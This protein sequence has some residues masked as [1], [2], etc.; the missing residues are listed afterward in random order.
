MSR[1]LIFAGAYGLAL[2]L[3]LLWQGLGEKDADPS[4]PELEEGKRTV[5]IFPGARQASPLLESLR[6]TFADS[7][8]VQILVREGFADSEAALAWD[9][10]VFENLDTGLRID[11]LGL[12]YGGV[13]ALQAASNYPTSVASVTLLSSVVSPRQELLGSAPLNAALKAFQFA[14]LWLVDK[15]V[16]HF[17][18]LDR[19]WYGVDYAGRVYRADLTDSEALFEELAQPV[20]LAGFEG[21]LGFSMHALRSA[22][23]A[24]PSASARLYPDRGDVSDLVRDLVDFWERPVSVGTAAGVA[25][26]DQPGNRLDPF[27][28]GGLLAVATFA[29]EDLACIGGGLLAASGSISLTVAILGCLL[30]IFIGDLGIYLLGRAAG[31]GT[32]DLPVFR[33]LASPRKIERVA[34]WFARKGVTLVVLTRFLP[35]SRVPTYFAAGVVGVGFWSFTFALLV[36]ATIWTPI[37]VGLS[38]F[39]GEQFLRLFEGIGSFGWLGIFFVAA[40]FVVVTRSLGQLMTWRGRRLMYSK[41]QRAIRWEFWPMWALYLPVLFYILWLMLRYRSSTLPSAVNPCMPVSGLVYE[42]KSR[43][44]SHLKGHGVPIGRFTMLELELDPEEKARRLRDFMSAEELDFPIALKPD[45]GERGQGVKIVDSMD[46]ARDFFAKNEGDTIVQE[47]LPGVEYGVFYHRFADEER[48]VVSSVTDKRMTFVVGDGRSNLERLILE[49]PRAV[50]MAR[51][52][53]E[54]YEDRLEEVPAAGERVWLASVG[55]HCRGALFLDGEDLITEELRDAIDG[56]SRP[57]EGFHFGRYDVRVPS[58]E[59]FKRGEG[60]RVIELNGLTSEP[61]SMYDPKHSIWFAWGCL[62]RQWRLIFELAKK[63]RLAGHEPVSLKKVSRL[64]WAYLRGSPSRD[65]F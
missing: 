13:D 9:R 59:A 45:V 60:L 58:E 61:T 27:W 25:F 7:V 37:L 33:R 47:Y 11:L 53:L 14:A 24:R 46:A 39:L 40:L 36:A 31:K 21:E 50:C 22:E 34:R 19:F 18:L 41:F 35:G 4:A 51:F 44:L 63:N 55:T 30:G 65:L 6:A 28:A 43:I 1:K 10:S 17:G 29:S 42:S 62:M 3:S 16:P 23:A 57:I 8:E 2:V 64:A 15:G 48:G 56:F 20:F 12:G 38:Y 26:E 32:L 5:V 52:F 49:D 54:E